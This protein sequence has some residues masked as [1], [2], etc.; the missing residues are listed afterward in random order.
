MRKSLWAE[1]TGFA[2]LMLLWRGPKILGHKFWTLVYQRA[3]AQCGPGTVFAMGVYID[4][5]KRVTIG[6]KCYL[7]QNV[8]IGAELADGNLVIEDNVQVSEGCSIDYS[9]Q[10]RIGNG[11]L[12]SPNVRILS[13][14]HGYDPRSEPLPFPLEIKSGVWIGIGALILPGTERIGHN[15]IVGAGAIVNCPVPD[16]AI[17]VGNPARVIK[18][19]SQD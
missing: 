2:L 3:I 9:G 13:H 15:A 1:S 6:A 18:Y 12:I 11:T 8:K 17:V 7:G 14:D 10:V 5:P 16:G 4:R 19:R